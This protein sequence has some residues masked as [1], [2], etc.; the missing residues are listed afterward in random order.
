MQNKKGC[1]ILVFVLFLIIAV[2]A[3]TGVPVTTETQGIDSDT[4]VD[5]L[6][7]TTETDEMVWQETSAYDFTL[8]DPILPHLY[9]FDDSYYTA[10]YQEDTLADQGLTS[11]TKSV[12]LDT[13]A[14]VENQ[15]NYETEKLVSFLGADTGLLTSDESILLDGAGTPMWNIFILT[16]PFGGGSFSDPASL[17]MNPAFCNIVDMGS[18]VTLFEGSFVTG[19][20]ERHVMAASPSIHGQ[21]MPLPIA[22]PGVEENYDIIVEG[23]DAGSVAMG[24]ADAYINAHIMEGRSMSTYITPYSAY[25]PLAEDIVYN[26]MSTAQGAIGLFQKSMSYKSQI[27]GRGFTSVG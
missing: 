1:L 25:H 10:S 19:S 24:Y 21:T 7:I 26:E 18:D 15:Y 27:T 23:I 22:D 6:G 20:E 4:M 14:K 17:T 16:C 11:Y 2:A 3:D 13:R 9:P 12:A 8:L 5:N